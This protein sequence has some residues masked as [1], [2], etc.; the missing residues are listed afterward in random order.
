VPKTVALLLDDSRNLYQQL[1][2]REATT[3]AR[4]HDLELLPPQFADGSGW[5]QVDA[6]NTLLRDARRPDAMLLMLAGGQSARASIER[7]PKA[8]VGLVLLNRLPD[9]LAELRRSYAQVLV[10]GVAPHQEQIGR[11]QAK[12]ALQLCVPGSFVILV[13]GTASSAAALERRKGFLDEAKGRFTVQE[14]DGRWSEAEAEKA[15]A[16]W[17]QLGAMRDRE[18]RVVVCQNDAMA[19][20]ARAALAR[21][22]A[23]TGRQGLARV[24]LVGCD[25]LAEEGCARVLRRELAAT[26]VVPATTPAAIEILRRHWQTGERPDQLLLDP[27]SFPTLQEIRPY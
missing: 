13:T 16:S 3:A 11:I 23:S 27:E 2:V 7:V 20:G 1:L 24:P 14:V 4:K 9:W 15:L 5:A 12:Q 8:G 10:A 22:A 25:G 19:A 26:V 21:Q 18:P 17:F 6:V